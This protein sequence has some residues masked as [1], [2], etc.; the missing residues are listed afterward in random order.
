M[1]LSARNAEVPI[2]W[3]ISAGHQ[4]LMSPCPKG[5]GHGDFHRIDPGESS[6]E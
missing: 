2:V 6:G 5:P 3:R 1:P 4:V